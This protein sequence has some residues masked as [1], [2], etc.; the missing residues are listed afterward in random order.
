MFQKQ[1]N[2][3]VHACCAFIVVEIIQRAF[4]PCG[5]PLWPCIQVKVIEMSMSIYAMHKSTVLPSLNA[6][7]RL[8]IVR[9]LTIIVQFK[10]WVLDAVVTFREGQGHRTGKDHVDLQSVYLRSKNSMGIT[11]TVSEIIEHLLCSWLTS[12]WPW[13]KVKKMMYHIW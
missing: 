7:F 2:V 1:V 3:Q 10:T 5:K 6:I 13:M 12:V 9:D 8:N 4:F 11:W